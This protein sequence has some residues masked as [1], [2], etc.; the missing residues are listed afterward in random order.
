MF[1]LSNISETTV[2]A[3]SINFMLYFKPSAHQHGVWPEHN[4]CAS[5]LLRIIDHYLMRITL[6]S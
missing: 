4:Q 1:L 2:V 3:I 6:E 5:I